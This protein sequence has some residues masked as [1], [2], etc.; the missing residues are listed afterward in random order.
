MSIPSMLFWVHR[1]MQKYNSILFD[2]WS[3]LGASPAVMIIG[4]DGSGRYRYRSAPLYVSQ[5][6]GGHVL[7]QTAATETNYEV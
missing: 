4:G 1:E 6:G 3:K 2:L 7:F 5:T